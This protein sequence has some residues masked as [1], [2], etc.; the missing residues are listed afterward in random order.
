M[1][2]VNF[3]VA[4]GEITLFA[5]PIPS[6]SVRFGDLFRCPQS[7]SVKKIQ[8]SKY[9]LNYNRKW[10]SKTVPTGTRILVY[11]Y[12]VSGFQPCYMRVRLELSG[13]PCYWLLSSLSNM[14]TG[15]NIKTWP[16]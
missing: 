2:F 15:R 8:K 9:L 12:W 14:F 1:I 5:S 3:L 6:K 10:Y 7:R 4:R 11:R 13:E 16:S